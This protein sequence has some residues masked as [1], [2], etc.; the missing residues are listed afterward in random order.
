MLALKKLLSIDKSNYY[1][2]GN[3]DGYSVKEIIEVARKI[4]GHPIPAI[5]SE[6]RVGDPAV[7]VAD[8]T[9]IQK[10]LGWKPKY[11]LKAI[12][13]SAWEWHKNNPEG[14]KK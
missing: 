9:K 12:I 8:S 5:K 10:E 11:D 14:F 2:L 4:T 3:G 7:L 13:K 1:N 6:R